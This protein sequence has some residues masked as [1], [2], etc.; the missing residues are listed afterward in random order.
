MLPERLSNG[1]CSL[2]PNEDKCCYSCI[3]E[4]DNHAVVKKYRIVHTLINSDRRFAYEEVQ[5][6]IDGAE[7]DFKEEILHAMRCQTVAPE[8]FRSRRHQLRSL[9]N[10]IQ[11]R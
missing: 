10:E 1:L 8:T 9:G 11:H 7:G 3:F 5:D 2:R 6:I 4:M